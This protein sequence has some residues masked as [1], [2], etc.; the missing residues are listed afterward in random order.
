M[1]S[2]RVLLLL[3]VVSA[4]NL[5]S[6][7]THAQDVSLTLQSSV[8]SVYLDDLRNDGVVIPLQWSTDAELTETMHITIEQVVSR[9]GLLDIQIP[10]TTIW[11]RQPGLIYVAPVFFTDLTEI[12]LL[13]RLM[14]EE[15]TLATADYSIDVVDDASP[16]QPDVTITRFELLTVEPDAN[17]QLTA[18]VTWQV[19]N[20]PLD[21]NL[22]FEQVLADD[23][24]LNIERDRA[25]ILV[26]SEGQGVGTLQETTTEIVQVRLRLIDLESGR[27]LTQALSTTD[28]PPPA[29]PTPTPL[30]NST[31]NIISFSITPN[32]TD[33]G[34]NITL[35]WQTHGMSSLSITRL[36]EVGRVFLESIASDLDDI[37]SFSYQLAD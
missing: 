34:G 37:G 26:A 36:S 8:S 27:V 28:Y 20:R 14:D 25:D 29:F 7:P 22:V 15:V 9:E 12:Y 18:K 24:I 16:V 4:G 1:K 10:H 2:I 23:T 32:P 3:A 6:L 5:W 19:D 13:A 21:T 30:S 35:S 31:A 11:Q 17:G 33:R